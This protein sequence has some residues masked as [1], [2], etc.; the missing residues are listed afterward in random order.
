MPLFD[1]VKDGGDTHD[2]NVLR[3][4]GVYVE[5]LFCLGALPDQY[6]YFL[7]E[8]NPFNILFIIVWFVCQGLPVGNSV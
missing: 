3:T 8:N 6:N 5:S 1:P 7:H 4:F 2:T